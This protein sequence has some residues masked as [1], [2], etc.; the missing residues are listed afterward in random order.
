M[1]TAL[2]SNRRLRRILR[3]TLFMALFGATL[4][5]M[6]ACGPSSPGGQ[7]E[8]AAS[9]QLAAVPGVDAA[10]VGTESV[11]SG[12]VAE[13]SAVGHLTLES[14]ATIP[15][16][17]KLLEYAIA[18]TWSANQREPGKRLL[19]SIETPG[20]TDADLLA[21]ATSLG[22]DT[23][24]ASRAG[25]V[26]VRVDE[27]RSKLGAWPGTVPSAPDGVTTGADK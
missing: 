22:W 4:V 27:V 8:A 20:G 9:T 18:V 26:S 7:S 21:A 23:A 12:L 6:T 15:D 11:Y 2:C 13:T 10:R 14:T 1:T 24:L 3:V 19:V 5:T 17:P 16:L 25:F